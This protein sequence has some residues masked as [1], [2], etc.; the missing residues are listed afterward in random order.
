MDLVPRVAQLITTDCWS[1]SS[2]S[3]TKGLLQDG[4]DV[5][6]GR[7]EVLQ[8]MFSNCRM[9]MTYRYVVH[10]LLGCALVSFTLG[11]DAPQVNLGYAAYQSLNDHG[12]YALNQFYRLR[13]G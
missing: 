4:R 9:T 3:S 5:E 11:L 8:S 6:D 1:A 12:K 13:N 2:S 10:A 7:E